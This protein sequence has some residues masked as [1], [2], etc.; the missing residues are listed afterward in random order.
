MKNNE[1]EKLKKCPH[2][3]KT[4]HQIKAGFNVSGTQRYKCKEWGKYYTLEL[5]KY[6]YRIIH[7]KRKCLFLLL[8]S[9]NCSF[10]H[11]PKKQVLY[12]ICNIML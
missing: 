2:C 9:F 6:H 5:A 3:G 12:K 8:I 4:E 10:G 11:S 7:K 1:T